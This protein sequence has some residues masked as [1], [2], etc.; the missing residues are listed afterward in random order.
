MEE[1]VDN[2]CD[3]IKHRHID[4]LQTGICTI[5]HGYVFNDL[6]TSYERISDHC[7]NIAVAMIE[8]EHD[9]FDTH[10]YLENRLNMK[11]EEFDRYY[12]E[13]EAKYSL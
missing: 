7:S 12:R 9:S 1:L 6:L 3:E 2:L 8:L 10:N 13:F 11:D 4:R 5:Q